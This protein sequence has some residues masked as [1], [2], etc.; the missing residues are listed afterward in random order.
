ML[1]P[2]ITV[3]I[4]G[5]DGIL[6]EDEP[7]RPILKRTPYRTMLWYVNKML[8]RKDARVVFVSRRGDNRRDDT[9]SW[10]N[11]YTNWTTEA[12]NP[13]LF[14]FNVKD[15]EVR[16]FKADAAKRASRKTSARP[17][18]IECYDHDIEVLKM[19]N[20]TLKPLCKQLKLHVVSQGVAERWKL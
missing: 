19:Y 20:A 17:V 11:R 6:C 18:A 15:Q 12:I 9:M 3:V 4:V 1:P 13:P 8:R 14:Y 2:E 16:L 10:L 5:V 7:M